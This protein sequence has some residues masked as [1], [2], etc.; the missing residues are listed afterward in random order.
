MVHVMAPSR[1]HALLAVVAVA[2]VLI[3]AAP[4]RGTIVTKCPGQS[5]MIP[6]TWRSY[7]FGR[8]WISA[9]ADWT[10]LHDDN[11]PGLSS[12]GA[13]ELGLPADGS[14][15]CP[16]GMANRDVVRVSTLPRGDPL[17]D[18][19][20]RIPIHGLEVTVTPCT[21]SNPAGAVLYLIPTLGVEALGTGGVDDNVTGPVA[22][23]LV[24]RVLHTIRRSEGLAHD[25]C[26]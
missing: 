21:S 25:R 16:S 14:E 9:P 20:P 11:C 2:L 1:I 13:L 5:V 23:S 8:V 12:V 10:V 26:S 18:S 6:Q 7:T 15:S 17:V 3:D 4:T 24:D 22:R 19:C